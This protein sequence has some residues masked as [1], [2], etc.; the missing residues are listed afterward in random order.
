MTQLE[1]PRCM[2]E[3]KNTVFSLLRSFDQKKW[4]TG[5]CCA[6]RRKYLRGLEAPY[7]WTSP[8]HTFPIK[9]KK[10]FFSLQLDKR[11]QEPSLEVQKMVFHKPSSCLHQPQ[12][13]CHLT[14]DVFPSLLR[15]HQS[16][17]LKE[18][19]PSHIETMSIYTTKNSDTRTARW[20]RRV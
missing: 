16:Y 10:G 18:R 5:S 7:E 8:R 15:S 20:C 14:S 2:I 4:Q 17:Q 6:T 3:K 19:P 1:V 13:T 9:A 11:Q 12:E